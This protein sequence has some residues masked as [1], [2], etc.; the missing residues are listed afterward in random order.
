[1]VTYILTRSIQPQTIPQTQGKGHRTRCQGCGISAT[2]ELRS[3]TRGGYGGSLEYELCT[4]Q[5]NEK[6]HFHGLLSVLAL[7]LRGQ[8][9][10][11]MCDIYRSEERSC[12][13]R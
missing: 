3:A 8:S 7:V 13:E 9:P 10:L 1:M 5:P 2:C 12:R 4:R 6:Y 11:V